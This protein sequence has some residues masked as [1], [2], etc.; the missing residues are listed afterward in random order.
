[1]SLVALTTVVPGYLDY[2]LVRIR[3][4]LDDPDACD[5]H[6]CRD[7]RKALMT[8]V[9]MMSMMALAQLRRLWP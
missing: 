7:A 5:V 1:M 4:V 9:F 6:D 3:T 2:C 8:V